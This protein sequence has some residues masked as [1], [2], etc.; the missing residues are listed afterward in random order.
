MSCSLD[1][2]LFLEEGEEG[3]EKLMLA[4]QSCGHRRNGG[5][6]EGMRLDVALDQKREGKGR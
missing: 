1:F 4:F 6:K 2:V 3:R 5:G